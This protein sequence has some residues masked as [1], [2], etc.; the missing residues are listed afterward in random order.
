MTHPPMSADPDGLIH[1]VSRVPVV[2]AG[3]CRVTWYAI[4]YLPAAGACAEAR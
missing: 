2:S 4:V 3:S 1:S